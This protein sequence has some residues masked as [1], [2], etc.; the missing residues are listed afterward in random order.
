MDTCLRPYAHTVFFLESRGVSICATPSTISALG[1][2]SPRAQAKRGGIN[3]HAIERTP[4]V[5]S[6]DQKKE[7]RSFEYQK[8]RRGRGRSKCIVERHV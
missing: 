5:L 1:L 3:A 6:R 2:L 7:R 4:R 8:K